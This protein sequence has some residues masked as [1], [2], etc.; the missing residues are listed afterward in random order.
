MFWLD[1]PPQTI[2]NVRIEERL[3]GTVAVTAC[4]D[5]K[6]HTGKF[7]SGHP[8]NLWVYTYSTMIVGFSFS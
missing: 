2:V 3:S 4:S 5:I 6:M 7:V 1:N 8:L